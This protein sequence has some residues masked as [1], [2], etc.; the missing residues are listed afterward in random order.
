M[1]EPVVQQMELWSQS[2]LSELP[3]LKA[4]FPHYHRHSDSSCYEQRFVSKI[5]SRTAC[6]DDD[7]PGCTPPIAARQDIE[8]DSPVFE[9]ASQ[10]HYKRSFP[11]PPDRQ[12]A[13][14]DDGSLQPALLQSAAVIKGVAHTH[15][16][17][18]KRSQEFHQARSP[19]RCHRTVPAGFETGR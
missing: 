19:R 5:T 11:S 8:L 13:Y 7:G 4:I 2:F 17:T 6:L 16:F 9:Q 12:I 15:A 1:L 18:V 14:A 10:K 3:G